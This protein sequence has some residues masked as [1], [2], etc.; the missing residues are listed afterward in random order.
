MQDNNHTLEFVKNRGTSTNNLDFDEEWWTKQL[1]NYLFRAWVMGL[2]TPGG[3]QA[4]AK[5][6][7]TGVGMLESTVLLYGRIPEPGVSSG[8]NLHNL[9]DAPLEEC[10]D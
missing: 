9:F 5:F 8:E 2:N 3:R 7:A 4:L 1:N 6:V 10:E